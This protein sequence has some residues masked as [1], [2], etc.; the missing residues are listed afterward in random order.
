MW[1]EKV[2]AE[3][4]REVWT[5]P[6]KEDLEGSPNGLDR[7]QYTERIPVWLTPDRGFR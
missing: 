6:K 4:D 2:P 3:R 7:P 1:R 5:R